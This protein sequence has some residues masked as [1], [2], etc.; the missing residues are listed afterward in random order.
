MDKVV[1]HH[2][3]SDYGKDS[4]IGFRSQKICEYSKNK[5]NITVIC[6]SNKSNSSNKKNIWTI[7]LSYLFFRFFALI[8]IYFFSNFPARKYELF[9]FNLLSIP[10]II[11]HFFRNIK[12]KR[13]FHSWDSTFWFLYFT[14]ILGYYI[15]K[16]C[17]MTPS[18]SSLIEA[19]KNPNFYVDKTTNQKK[20]NSEKKIFE[21][22]DKIISPSIYTSNFIIKEYQINSHKLKT[23]PFG[24]DL[25][26]KLIIQKRKNKK[27]IR[28]GFVGLVNMRKGIR[29]LISVLNYCYEKDNLK[30]ELHLFGRIFKEEIDTLEGAKFKIIKYGFVDKNKKN[31]Y[32]SFDI[33]I[34]PSF[35]EG[36]A[37][38]IYEAMASG[39]PIICTEQ[40]G[41]LVQNKKN[42]YVINAGDSK[43]LKNAIKFFI[44]NKKYI[45]IMGIRS[46]KIIRNFSWEKY[47]EK[48]VENY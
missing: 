42:G 41:S 17:A 11:F 33:L 37:K 22:S 7:D 30:F 34:H 32:D 40:S 28:L 12:K 39:L 4:S 43:S 45:H 9:I 44:D 18:K 5:N 20:I 8:R 6:R 25:I 16:D 1:L 21:I 3:A 29:W 14:K 10:Y 24:A 15:I 2:I 31:I 38:C 19:K 47:A 27:I 46:K 26:D 13:Y 35:I 23:I 36:S 48:V